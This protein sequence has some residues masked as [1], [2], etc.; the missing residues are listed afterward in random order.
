MSIVRIHNIILQIV[1]NGDISLLRHIDSLY[2]RY[3]YGV[4]FLFL[5]IGC[6]AK[7][8]NNTEVQETVGEP[9]YRKEGHPEIAA[10]LEEYES[11]IGD[12]AQMDNDVGFLLGDTWIYFQGGKMLTKENFRDKDQYQSIFYDY[13]LGR[14]TGTGLYRGNSL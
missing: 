6:A 5:F 8:V 7:S 10:L 1:P 4:L 3:T 12:V 2:K 14:L 11:F 9:G 13:T